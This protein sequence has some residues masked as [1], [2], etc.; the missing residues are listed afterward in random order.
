MAFLL[1]LHML[2][3]PSIF[4]LFAQAKKLDDQCTNSHNTLE[5]EEVG[6]GRTPF[7]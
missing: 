4:G 2:T 1:T 3:T 5:P 7:T 6:H